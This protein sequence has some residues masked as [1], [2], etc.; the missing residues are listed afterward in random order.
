LTALPVFAIEVPIELPAAAPLEAC[1]PR[2][3]KGFHADDEA[4]PLRLIPKTINP[5][6][7]CFR[8][9]LAAARQRVGR[10][11]LHAF[12][13]SCIILSSRTIDTIPVSFHSAFHRRRLE[14]TRKRLWN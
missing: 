3:L 12:R 10:S 9:P 8:A 1:E 7:I 5:P 14:R 11:V 13:L 6:K 2:E 4:Q